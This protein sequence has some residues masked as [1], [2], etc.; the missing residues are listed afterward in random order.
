MEMN[1]NECFLM[2]EDLVHGEGKTEFISTYLKCN[3]IHLL[4]Q[5]PVP[6]T[7]SPRQVRETKS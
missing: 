2:L 3:I 5:I 1:G 7:K 6:L 4:N